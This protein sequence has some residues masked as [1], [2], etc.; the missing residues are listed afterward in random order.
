VRVM[1]RRHNPLHFGVAVG[2]DRYP[3]FPGFDLASA[4]ED[5][6]AFRDWLVADDGGGLPA[7]NVALVVATATE[8]W[9]STFDARPHVREI[10]RALY[11][12]N[13]RIRDHI[14]S[15]PGDWA[16]TRVYVYAAGH[17]VGPPRGECGVL[18]ADSDPDLLGNYIDVS[19]YR[20]WYLA[21]GLVREVAIFAD[22]C[23]EIVRGVPPANEL[24]FTACDLKGPTGTAAFTAYATRLGEKAW[25]ARTVAE[26]D[27][28]RGYFTRALLDG[29]RGGAADT[30]GAVTSPALGEYVE[31]ALAELA[32][33][34]PFPQ[35]AEP[36][37]KPGSALVFGGDRD[38]VLHRASVRFPAG[39]TDPVIVR[40]GRGVEHGPWTPSDG[41]WQLD[42]P[43]GFYEVAISGAAA[44]DHRSWL[45]K[46]VATDVEV[47]L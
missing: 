4:A 45:F 12:F 32:R 26:R 30:S 9:P 37:H 3:G 21:C 14:R 31:I 6:M 43:D 8:R 38:R 29:L 35:E 10:N 11:G 25:E 46:V 47:Q 44:D 13:A 2:I 27:G 36:H 15:R 34:A 40:A 18:M 16:A 5:A 22:C 41:G 39:F 17:G 28:A 1:P 23:R 19:K 24:P 20:D 42:L 7:D 33:N